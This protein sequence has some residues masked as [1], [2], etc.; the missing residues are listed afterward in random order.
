MTAASAPTPDFP[1]ASAE[2]PAAPGAASVPWERVD[3]FIG[4]FTH[5]IRNSL[6]ALEL[7]LTFLGEISTDPDAVAEVKQLRATLGGLTRQ[8]QAVKLKTGSVSPYT[9]EY[10]ARD[11]LEDLRERFE[12]LQSADAGRVSWEVSVDGAVLL[13]DPE[14]SI[15]ALLEMLGNSLYFGGPGGEVKFAAASLPQG[16]ARVTL[17]QELPQAPTIPPGNWGREPLHTTRRNAYG[18]G[19]FRA[20]RV[21]EAQGISLDAAWDPAGHLLTTTIG[22]PSPTGPTA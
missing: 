10:P 13:V 7:Q 11:F 8:L 9:M 22:F 18:L 17:T 14:L 20:R 16:G 4:Q 2:N 1:S 19:M 12:R 6:N 3:R 5:D 21:L 15:G